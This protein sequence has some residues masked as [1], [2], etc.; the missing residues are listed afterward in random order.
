MKSKLNKQLKRT[1]RQHAST[2]SSSDDDS[3]QPVKRQ[4]VEHYCYCH[5]T[6]YSHTSAECKVMEAAKKRFTSAMRNATNS[7]SPPGGSVRKPGE[8][9]VRWRSGEESS[10]ISYAKRIR[11]AACNGSTFALATNLLE[12]DLAG[13]DA[14]VEINMDLRNTGLTTL[15]LV[16]DCIKSNSMCANP[17]RAWN[18]D[19]SREGIEETRVPFGYSLR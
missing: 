4:R 5:G 10:S 14:E 12:S 13:H 1:K 17:V 18:L 16:R 19:S 3:E 11:A 15:A 8:P 2:T 9:Y 7:Q 6:Q